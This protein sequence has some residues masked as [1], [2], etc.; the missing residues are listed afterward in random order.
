MRILLGD[1]LYTTVFG[2]F[3]PLTP[4]AEHTKASSARTLLY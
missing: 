4:A 2:A 3:A 1:A